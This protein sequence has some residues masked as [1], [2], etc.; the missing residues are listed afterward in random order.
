MNG[1]MLYLSNIGHLLKNRKPQNKLLRLQAIFGY[2]KL[3][4]EK[5]ANN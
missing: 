3:M 1:T 2:M 5:A 4:C